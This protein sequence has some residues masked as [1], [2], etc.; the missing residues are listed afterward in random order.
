[1][2]MRAHVLARVGTRSAD[3]KRR[4]E[5]PEMVQRNCIVD[6]PGDEMGDGELVEPAV[7]LY[8]PDP[9]FSF[10]Q[11]VHNLYSRERLKPRV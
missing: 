3:L 7:R 9:R 11:R 6:P 2:L 4:V 5:H 8:N 1:M 10:D